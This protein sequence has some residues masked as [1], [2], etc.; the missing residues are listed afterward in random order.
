[1]R[2]AYGKLMYLLQDAVQ[3]EEELGIDCVSD[4][5]TVADTLKRLGLEKVLADD[6]LVVATTP[7]PMLEPRKLLNKALRHKDLVVKHLLDTYCGRDQKKRE[8]LELCIRSIDD[9]NCH[10]RDNAK[11][12][13]RMIILLKDHFRRDGPTDAQYSLA[14]DVGQGGS[15][16]KHA[17][18]FQYLYVLQSL[19]LWRIVSREM[20]RLWW[21]V[22]QDLLDSKNAPYE[23]RNTGQGFSRVQPSPRIYK[24]MQE[25]VV[26]VGVETGTEMVGERRVHI[27]DDQVPNALLFIDKYSGVSRM[28]N[29]I[30]RT[31]DY[32]ERVMASKPNKDTP[33]SISKDYIKTTWGDAQHLVRTILSD[34]FRHAFDGSGGDNMLDAGSCID[35]RLTSAWNWCQNIRS[36][37]FYPV[38]LMAGFSSFDDDLEAD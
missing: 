15:R 18:D 35:G 11:C 21:L 8:V 37:P 10:I 9:A 16:L 5:V 7:V 12:I 32:V 22:E 36:K 1:M 33:Q 25:I 31:I 6:Q 27:G 19:N 34:F 38:F 3:L 26:Q 2:A 20:Y 29:P 30:L 23:F 24:A 28:I 14:L 13:E 4:I 17:H